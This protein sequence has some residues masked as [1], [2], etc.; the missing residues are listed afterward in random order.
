MPD[1]SAL[2]CGSSTRHEG[3]GEKIYKTLRPQP[4]GGTPQEALVVRLETQR[5]VCTQPDTGMSLWASKATLTTRAYRPT[6]RRSDE[7]SALS[8][9]WLLPLS[10][11]AQVSRFSTRMGAAWA[12]AS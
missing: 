5:E 4:C 12:P 2:S 1:V 9:L 7:I 3:E 10:L 6:Q 8:F 11:L